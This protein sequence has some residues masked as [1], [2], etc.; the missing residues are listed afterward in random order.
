MKVIVTGGCGFIGSNLVD[1][2]IKLKHD[3]VV[4]DNL[5]TGKKENLNPKAR[6]YLVDIR[7]KEKVEDIFKKEK[8]EI[9]NHH[10]AQ[11]D[12]RK[13]VSDPGYDASVNIIGLINLLKA[14]VDNKVKKFINVSSGGVIY[15]DDAKL[16]IKEN[17]KK[18]PI[19]PYGISKLS[20]EYYVNFFNKI[21]GLNFTTL[22]YSNV[23]GPRQ[24]PKGEAGVISIFSNLM[25]NNKQPTIFGD[26]K[27]TRD[28]VFVK[29]VVNA[30]I[31]AMEKGDNQAFNIGTMRETSVNELFS[32]MKDIIG[33][34]GNPIYAEAR[35]GELLRNCLDNSKAKKLL[36]WQPK[37]SLKEG[38]KQTIDWVKSF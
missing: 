14:S 10:A 32:I 17:E 1:E 30:N 27:Q 7:E 6:F 20:G 31:L 36:G 35:A 37:Y 13:S 15:G 28:Y 19:S 2:L 38:L 26:G 12:V 23:Y 11:I 8:P 4:I 9:V 34:K 5:S 33:F 21:Y 22:R 16:P 29:D 3:V 24:D 18:N 25:L